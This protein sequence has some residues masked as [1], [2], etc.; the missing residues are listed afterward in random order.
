MAHYPQPI[1]ALSSCMKKMGGVTVSK[2]P[3]AM[4]AHWMLGDRLLN[5]RPSIPWLLL[6]IC[7][8]VLVAV[9]DHEKPYSSLC[10]AAPRLLTLMVC[11]SLTA[12]SAHW[13]SEIN[14]LSAS[15]H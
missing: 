7:Q 13:I 6:G 1:S 4:R 15:M 3:L 10:L 2:H 14:A 12:A 5:I 11:L 9:T 8:L